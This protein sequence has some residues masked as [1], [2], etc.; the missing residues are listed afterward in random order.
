MIFPLPAGLHQH[1]L[2]VPYAISICVLL[3]FW[4]VYTWLVVSPQLSSNIQCSSF[5]GSLVVF[6]S[7][8]MSSLD[9]SVGPVV[10]TLCFHCSGHELDPW[11]GNWDSHTPYGASKKKSHHWLDILVSYGCM[12]ADWIV[13]RFVFCFFFI[14]KVFFLLF[15]L[16]LFLNFT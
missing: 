10:R 2:N 5:D 4:L 9:F 7:V 11:L 15:F 16:I 12:A 1:I 3:C 14:N 13:L 6:I 8:K